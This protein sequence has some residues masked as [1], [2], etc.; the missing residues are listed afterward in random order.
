LD[1]PQLKLATYQLAGGSKQALNV[2]PKKTMFTLQAANHAEPTEYCPF[3]S[4]VT[5]ELP[6]KKTE[7]LL[8]S[9]LL[10]RTLPAPSCFIEWKVVEPKKISY[11]L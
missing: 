2:G 1:P 3:N 7:R 10:F 8:D 9:L 4:N 6:L 11:P 5:L